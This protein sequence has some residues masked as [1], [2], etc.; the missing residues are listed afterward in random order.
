MASGSLTIAEVADRSG[1]NIATLRA[2]ER[3]HGFPVPE[4]HASGH[5][6]FE[7]R[8]VDAIRQV[9][10]A[11]ER[12]LSLDAAIAV[13]RQAE[14]PTDA[15]VYAGLRRAHPELHPHDLSRR[16]MLAISRAIEDEATASGDRAHLVV[17]FQRTS[18]Y[19]DARRHRWS[20][21]SG[22]AES[23]IVFADFRAS[24]ST[25]DVL[26]VAIPEG[27]PQRREWALVVDA[28]TSAMAMAGWERADGRYEAVWTAE[29]SA[30]RT[31]TVVGRLL[32]AQQAPTLALPPAL[33]HEPAVDD[34]GRR[35]VRVANRI[36]TRLDR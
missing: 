6:R 5:R 17:A 24:R 25:R 26:E 31:A 29:P 3:R 18:A 33:I 8:D 34:G 19:R 16:A 32:A 20:E 9:V 7:D 23:T 10:A 12:G 11:R 22:T 13:V 2:W 15:T 21:L 4:R 36:V 35:A 14:E 28:P 1:V 30:V 27:A